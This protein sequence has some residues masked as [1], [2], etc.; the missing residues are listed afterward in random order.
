MPDPSLLKS[1]SET[2]TTSGHR[3][4]FVMVARDEPPALLEATIQGLL[5]TSAGCAREIVV[6]DDGSCVPV[7]LAWPDVSVARILEPIGTA[8]ARR[9]G[10]A[11]TTGDILVFMDA[12]MRFAP[13]WLD[14]MLPH[15]EAG[16]LLCAAWWDYDLTHPLCWGADFHWCDER[17]YAAGRSPGFTYRHRTKYPGDGAVDVPMLIGACYMMRRESYVRLG[18]F[19]PF[20]RTWGKL[21]QDLSAR[22]RIFGFDIKCVTSAHVGHFTRPKHPYPV[23]WA[24][25]EFNQVATARTAFEEPVGKAM[26]QLL[27]PLPSQV[28]EWLAK[29]DFGGWR[30]WV[31]SQR[32]ISDAEFFRRFVH[33]IPECLLQAAQIESTEFGA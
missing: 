26:E 20:F 16:V 30:K 17:D 23:S 11:V 18:G 6:V 32:R 5:Q 8:R 24:D 28:G 10:A 31:Q 9:H 22:A 1:F 7:P 33:N 27:Q 25:V 19:S 13:D 3:L 12:H 2:S 15:V 4:S 14:R 21:E 29:V